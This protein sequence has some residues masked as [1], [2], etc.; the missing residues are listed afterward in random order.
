ML[1]L[2]LP[3]AVDHL[4]KVLSSFDWRI[5][6]VVFIVGSAA[7]FARSGFDSPRGLGRREAASQV[8]LRNQRRV[9]RYIQSKVNP[10]LE[11]LVT[12]VLLERPDNPVPFM[13]RWLAERSKTG[14]LDV[15]GA[16]E[17]RSKESLYSLGVGEAEKL[18]NE[19]KELQEPGT[20]EI[21]VLSD[22]VGEA[23]AKG[24]ETTP[25]AP[26]A[27]VSGEATE[28]PPPAQ[29]ALVWSSM[30][31]REDARKDTD[32]KG[33][34]ESSVSAEAYG[35]FNEKKAF[36]PP[37]YEKSTEQESRIKDVLSKSFLFNALSKDDLKVILDAFLEKKIPAGERIIQEGDDGDVMFLIESG[38]F[39]CIKKID[40]SDKV[41]K[42]CGQGDVF[43][44]L[45]LLYNCPRAASVEADR[46]VA[47][48]EEAV[49]WQLDRE[50]FSHIVR[51]ASAK[52]REAF[53]DFLKTVPLFKTLESYDLM[54]LADCLQQE[55]LEAGQKIINQGDPGDTFYIVEE[56]E[57]VATKKR[58]DGSNEEVLDYKRGD[59]FGE[60]ALIKNE[61]RAA[62]VEA[63]TASKI[64]SLT[65][66]EVNGA[67]GWIDLLFKN[68]LQV[69]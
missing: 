44:E 15:E 69:G 20:D 12:E 51:D 18:R 67:L 13:V 30:G 31:V 34:E 28:K 68:H 38:A 46:A 42:K 35:A 8:A 3:P 58:A 62:T 32:P 22:K 57:L 1:A 53:Q 47:A 10:I 61:P 45:A 49:V 48:T 9:K 50:T 60:L 26:E 19:I 55:G 29:E 7:Q 64:C 37:V 66:V 25:E 43:G 24:A 52:R 40:G 54:Q 6:L 21:K 14:S 56:G 11:N 36:E 41:V 17:H 65:L 39:D 33:K 23:K 63:K 5:W 16:L 27:A 4:V 2:A 59:F